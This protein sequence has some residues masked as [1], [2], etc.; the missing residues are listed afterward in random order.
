MIYTITLNPSIDYIVQI[1]QLNLG[2]LNRM[3]QDYK[4][5]GGKGINVSR[6][7]NQLNV[8]NLATGFLGGF[9]GGFIKDWLKNEGVKTGFVTVQDDT[10]INIKLKHGEETEIN[11]LGPTISE[12]EINEFFAVMDKV[13]ANDVVILSGSVPPSLGNNFY[14]KI[15]RICK[16]KQAEFMIDTTGQELLNALPNMPIL[17]KPNHHELAEL[18]DVQLNSVEELIPYGKKCLELGAQH[19][20]VSMAGDGALFFTGE[21]V[22]FAEALKGELKNSVGAGDSMIAGFI[23]AFDKTRDPLKAFEAGVATG[24]A[25][26]FSTDLA[27]AELINKL[28]PQVN[29]TKITGRN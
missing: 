12:K 3:K 25:T 13:T 7:L 5:P 21:D 1:D 9:T 27:Q 4:L 23:G 18:F 19:V 8:P 10:R 15:I 29:I 16:K 6:V 2:E 17:I 14:N 24:G 22:Y 26:A 20:I 11:G 28:L